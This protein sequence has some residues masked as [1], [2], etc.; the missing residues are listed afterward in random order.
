MTMMPMMMTNF[1]AC[2]AE[3][4]GKTNKSDVN[5][6]HGAKMA[7][8]VSDA[9][10]VTNRTEATTA[11]MHSVRVRCVWDAMVIFKVN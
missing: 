4:V 11:S 8:L 9:L 7:I 10:N 1:S 6:V 3:E 5:L 2:G